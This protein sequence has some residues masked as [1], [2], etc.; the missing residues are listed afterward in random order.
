MGV[1]LQQISA[2]PSKQIQEVLP[3]VVNTRNHAVSA[4]WT[5]Q[6]SSALHHPLTLSQ[7]ASPS[8]PPLTF[9]R[10]FEPI[11]HACRIWSPRVQGCRTQPA[12]GG[13]SS[14]KWGQS[15]SALPGL[16]PGVTPWDGDLRLQREIAMA[17]SEA[18]L[19]LL[20]IFPS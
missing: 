11:K 13:D 5:P 2:F 19:H 10:Q 12:L 16:R 18:V 3:G 17:G 1:L 20:V 15:H 4:A 7:P 9:S 6:P 14:G 8:Q